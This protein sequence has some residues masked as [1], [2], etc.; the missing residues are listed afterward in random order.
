M[1]Q[2]NYTS[3]NDDDTLSISFVIKL[4]DNNMTQ[5]GNPIQLDVNVTFGPLVLKRSVTIKVLRTEK[6]T[7]DFN[8]FT[9]MITSN[10]KYTS[11]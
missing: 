2:L 7:L 4:T 1:G 5:N 6:E 10:A 3:P 11:T 8:V 9:N